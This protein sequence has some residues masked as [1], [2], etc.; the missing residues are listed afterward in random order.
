VC[1]L[2]HSY[3]LTASVLSEFESGTAPVSQS[4]PQHLPSARLTGGRIFPS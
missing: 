4:P 3:S 2:A 1:Q